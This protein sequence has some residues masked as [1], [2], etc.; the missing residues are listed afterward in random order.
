MANSGNASLVVSYKQEA[1]SNQALTPL[2]GQGITQGVSI[3]QAISAGAAA[4]QADRSYGTTLSVATSGST[5]VDLYQLGSATNPVGQ[6]YAG[7]TKLKFLS[8]ENLSVGSDV[9][10]SIG[11]AASDPFISIFGGTTP[12]FKINPGAAAVLVWDF[13]ANGMLISNTNKNLKVT[14]PSA[15]NI[16]SFKI[17]AIFA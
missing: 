13:S 8:I 2:T 9:I 16:G 12:V 7:N 10:F 1:T 15:S 5:T 4:G 3:Q 14:N 17:V 6:S 11:A